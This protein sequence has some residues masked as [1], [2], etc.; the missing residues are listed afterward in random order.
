[1]KYNWNKFFLRLT[2]VVSIIAF[3][4]MVIHAHD[5]WIDRR[6]GSWHVRVEYWITHFFYGLIGPFC[7]WES[8]LLSDGFAWD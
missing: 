6:F 2:V 8:I 5:Y 4:V 7:I 1:M 3:V